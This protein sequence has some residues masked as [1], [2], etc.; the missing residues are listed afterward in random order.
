[1]YKKLQ[2]LNTAKFRES[3]IYYAGNFTLNF[4]RYLFHLVLLRLL[5]PPEYGEFLSYLSLMY[6]LA[7]PTGTIG[8][9]VTKFIA[10]YKGRGDDHSINVFF[11]YLLK[12]TTPVGLAVGI[13]LILLSNPLA[14]LFKAHPL[15]FIVLGVSTFISLFQ[16]IVSS[17]LAGFQKFLV[18]TV[19]GFVSVIFTI[20]LS[21]V[22]IK[23]GLGAS[24][25]VLGQII[26]GLA[27]TVLTL[28]YIKSSIYPKAIPTGKEKF[29]LKNFAFFSFIYSLG[30]MSLM[31]VD[32]LVVRVIF[33]THTSGLYSSLSIL[34]R[35]ILF[36]LTP[37]ISLV[38]PM[39]SLRYAKKISSR[40]IFFKLGLGITILGFLGSLVFTLIPKTII[41]VLSGSQYLEVSSLLPLF[42]YSMVLF[43]LSQYLL[44][45]LM[46]TN[47]EKANYLLLFA[48]AI[49]PLT[50]YFFGN[51]LWGVVVINLCVHTI[52]FL[53]LTFFLLYP[54]KSKLKFT[55]ET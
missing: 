8:S 36:G 34:G 11:Y 17:F 4:F 16:T 14:A 44:S 51:T 42:A 12:R 26:T 38:L 52:L 28:F 24:G 50:L 18:Q 19:L 32:I 48:A 15:A 2:K 49:Q 53:S 1:M 39:V 13:I 7:I 45:F 21:V 27:I 23:M 40:S 47:R 55:H 29:S 22:F 37:I 54:Y 31:S 5:T 33:D 25:A 35:M 30:T 41:S 9:L 46:A 20:G 10:D 6:I 43:A 3:L